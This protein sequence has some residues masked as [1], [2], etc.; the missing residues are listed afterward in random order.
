MLSPWQNASASTTEASRSRKS[1]LQQWKFPQSG[2]AELLRFLDD[3]GLG[4]VNRGKKISPERQLNYLNALRTPLEFFN[5]PTARLTLRDIEDF[6]KALSSGQ[7]A[8]QMHRA[9]P[10]PTTP[11][12]I[13]A[14][15]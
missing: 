11:R 14:C 9:S 6:E 12:S 8:Q 2:K 7:L 13:C 3:L 4:K 5:K 10:M 15:C 1:Q